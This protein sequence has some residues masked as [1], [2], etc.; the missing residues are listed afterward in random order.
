M[1]WKNSPLPYMVSW[2]TIETG[3]QSW[4]VRACWVRFFESVSLHQKKSP[5]GAQ[6]ESNMSELVCYTF[7]QDQSSRRAIVGIEDLYIGGLPRWGWA[8][9]WRLT[10]LM[11]MAQVREQL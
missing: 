1:S 5:G 10:H 9:V 8:E 3:K 7:G 4:E 2:G 11:G 6:R